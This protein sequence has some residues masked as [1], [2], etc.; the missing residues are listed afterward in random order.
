MCAKHFF[1]FLKLKTRFCPVFSSNSYFSTSDSDSTC[2]IL[3]EYRI[4]FL[5]KKCTFG[6]PGGLVGVWV[7]QSCENRNFT[8]PIFESDFDCLTGKHRILALSLLPLL[9]PI[10]HKKNL[11]NHTCTVYYSYSSFY[12]AIYFTNFD[13]RGKRERRDR[14]RLIFLLTFFGINRYK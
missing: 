2:S 4:K 11:K 8:H 7:P 6:L 1:T 12:L 14:A 10:I 13:T 9:P 3:L 5:H